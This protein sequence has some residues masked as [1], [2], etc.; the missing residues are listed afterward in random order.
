MNMKFAALAVLA[1]FG[2]MAAAPR[3][4]AADNGFYLGAGLTKTEF[5]ADDIDNVELDD[6]SFKVIAGFRPLDW[7]AFEANYI[8]LGSD[9]EDFGPFT[10]EIDANAITASVLGIFE[11][12]IVD[13]YARAG[14]AHWNVD[15]RQ[16][17][18]NT[19]IDGSDDGDEFTYGVGVGVHFGSIGVRAEYEKF[20]LGDL[21][22]DVNT[23][24]LSFTYTFL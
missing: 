18:G 7:L 14:L 9:S 2:L 23:V 24:S 5:D 6:S 15:L 16:D 19:V 20:E 11:V 22:T 3:A 21:D 1:T 12:G 13:L 8:D 4:Q 10:S 17:F